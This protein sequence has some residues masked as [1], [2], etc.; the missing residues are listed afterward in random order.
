MG[1]LGNIFDVTQ[2]NKPRGPDLRA[3]VEFPRGKLGQSHHA[4]LPNLV[5]CEGELVERA[6]V[7]RDASVPLTLAADFKS[8]STLRLRRQGGVCKGGVPGDLFLTV[9]LVDRVESSDLDPDD[10]PINGRLWLVI[11]I[12]GSAAVLAYGLS[13]L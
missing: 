9:K 3:T 1:Q 7:S 4:R 10:A 5:E 11:G 2:S 13:G 12:L 6:K 8:G